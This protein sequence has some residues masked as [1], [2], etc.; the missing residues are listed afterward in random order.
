MLTQAD[1][2]QAITV[3]VNYPDQQSTTASTASPATAPVE[4]VNDAPTGSVTVVGSGT[5]GG[6]GTILAQQGQTLTASNTLADADGIPAGAISYQWFRGTTAIEGATGT[7][8]VLT[9]ADVGAVIRVV[10][11]YTDQQGTA[12]TVS[13]T[14]TAAVEALPWAADD[15]VY[16][17]L[18]ASLTIKVASND[19]DA[20]GDLNPASTTIISGLSLGT[21]VVNAD[22]TVTYSDQITNLPAPSDQSATDTFI[23]QISDSHGNVDQATVQVN[24]IDPLRDVQTDTTQTANGQLLSLTV[25]TEDRTANASSFVNVDIGIGNLGAKDVNIAF[26][27]DASGSIAGPEYAQQIAVIQNTI[28]QLRTQF[29]G[30]LNDVS[31]SLIRFASDAQRSTTYNLNDA[32]L[33]DIKELSITAQTGGSTNYEAA[34]QRALTFFDEEDPS[35]K[36]EANFVFFASDGAPTNPTSYLDE[37]AL[38]K[39]AASVSAVGF[40]SQAQLGPLD[41]LDNTGGALVVPDAGALGQVFAT[42]PL[43]SAVLVDFELTLSVNSGLPTILANDVGDLVDN[44]DGTY[45]FDLAAVA[46]LLG[47]ETDQNVFE[48]RAV[49]DTDGDL[50]TT[51]DRLTLETVNNVQGAV[52]D[53]L[54]MI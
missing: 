44:G 52:P 7:S 29:A 21:A 11:S 45:S 48:A 46:G 1:V 37:A 33:N 39:Q 17:E 51:A 20:D 8:Y 30:A 32:A 23:Y 53:L 19:T 16:A 6:S 28:T 5:S 4:N 10:A 40:G 35:P 36:D 54:W 41:I 12:E 13:S 42:S 14:A 24:L 3:K 25:A 34:L 43:F 2:G 15:A 18:G 49:F 22:G 38:L 9:Q 26:V 31:V 50:S 47:R 27:F